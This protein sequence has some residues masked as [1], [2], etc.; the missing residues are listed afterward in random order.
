MARKRRRTK[1][2]GGAKKHPHGKATSKIK[3]DLLEDVV[4][5]IHA[6][7]GLS[8]RKNVWLRTPSGDEREIDV[9]ISGTVAG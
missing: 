3:G 4:A 1:K 6:A 9:L 5:K 2:K 7:P 8:V